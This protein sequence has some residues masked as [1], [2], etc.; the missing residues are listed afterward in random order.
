MNLTV[1]Y[2]LPSSTLF[3]NRSFNLSHF[4]LGYGTISIENSTANH[5]KPLSDHNVHGWPPVTKATAP[6]V[7]FLG[8]ANTVNWCATFYCK[9]KV[10]GARFSKVP[11]SLRA[12][13]AIRRTLTRL[14]CKAGLF[15]CFRGSK[16]L[17]KLQSFEPQMPSIQWGIVLKCTPHAQH[18]YFSSFDQSYCRVVV[19]VI[20][21]NAR[22]PLYPT[23]C[24]PR[25]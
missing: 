24:T 2:N 15:M 12:R 7:A 1:L 20:L 4:A 19:V 14:F 17:K 10:S 21:V 8:M 11:K 6:E 3:L 16:K 9:S 22:N 23:R 18:V 5:I 13:K 25:M